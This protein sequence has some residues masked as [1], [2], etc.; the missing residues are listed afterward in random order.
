MLLVSGINLQ[1]KSV[2]KSSANAQ[3]N[4]S[5]K[6]HTQPMRDTV[7]FS[8][9]LPDK[10]LAE[11]ENLSK[12]FGVELEP[13]TNSLNEFVSVKNFS[14]KKLEEIINRF[15][16]GYKKSQEELTGYHTKEDL[17]AFIPKLY[18]HYKKYGHDVELYDYDNRRKILRGSNLEIK[19]APAVF[20]RPEQKLIINKHSGPLTV[21]T[22]YPDTEEFSDAISMPMTRVLKSFCTDI[23]YSTKTRSKLL[24]F[25]G[26]KYLFSVFERN[27]ER[28]GTYPV[29]LRIVKK[30]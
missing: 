15:A 14:K 21:I 6:F 13:R 17:D 27:G 18:E 3:Q 16:E 11:V 22:G 26:E 19:T 23:R 25:G 12:L 2:N 28:G 5:I 4:P 7:S 9:A 20:D 1:P 10:L 24:E 8:G 30:S 29:E